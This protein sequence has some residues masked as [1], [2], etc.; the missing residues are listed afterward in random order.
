MRIPRSHAI[1]HALIDRYGLAT[2]PF[3]MDNAEAY[4]FFGG[5]KIRHREL[6]GDPRGLGFEVLPNESVAPA[7]LW[8][9]EL[10]PF[11]ARLREHGDDAWVEIAAEYDQYAVREFL[12]ARNWSEGAIEMFGLLFNQEALM[13]SSFL[14]LLREELGGYYSDLVYIDGGTDH[15]PARVPARARVADPLRHARSSPWTSPTTTSPSTAATP[16][17]AGRSSPT[18]WCS[19]CRSRCCA[20][21]RCS[22]RSPATSSARS[23]SS[24]TTRRPRCSCS[25]GGGSGKRTT[26]S[27]A[28]AP[29]PTSRCATCTT[30]TT[31]ATPDAA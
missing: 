10:E 7:Q 31:A 6:A 24:T 18:T 22:P 17:A 11:A 8:N 30:P 21:S 23:A 4:C 20:T 9:A 27:S 13:N 25:S 19:P 3:T 2:K 5:R 29:S 26:A 14:E 16:A 1:T 15:A 28:A 12:E